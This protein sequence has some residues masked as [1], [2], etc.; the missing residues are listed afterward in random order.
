MENL[1]FAATATDVADAA[2]A[3]AA[4]SAADADA[5]DA[6]AAGFIDSLLYRLHPTAAV[7][8]ITLDVRI[9]ENVPAP[10]EGKKKTSLWRMLCF[11]YFLWIFSVEIFLN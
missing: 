8:E 9:E 6:V 10:T 1:P 2:A 11:L 7:D 4:A 5:A 3:A